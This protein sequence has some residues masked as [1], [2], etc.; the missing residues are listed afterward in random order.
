MTQNECL[1]LVNQ[2]VMRAETEDN[3]YMFFFC[4][5]CKVFSQQLR[6]YG[7]FTFPLFFREGKAGIL[8]GILFFS[9]LSC[10]HMTFAC[11]AILHSNILEVS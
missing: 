8:R 1:H 9:D 10:T 3:V 7:G 11:M 5:M 2:R 6:C 4:Y